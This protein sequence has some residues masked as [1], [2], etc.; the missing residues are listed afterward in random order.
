MRKRKFLGGIRE[1][2]IL[3]GRAEGQHDGPSSGS[4]N[5]WKSEERILFFLFGK[6]NS[7]C[8]RRLFCGKKRV[9]IRT[10]QTGKTPTAGKRFSRN[11]RTST[12]GDISTSTT[13]SV[14]RIRTEWKSRFRLSQL[15]S[16]AGLCGIGVYGTARRLKKRQPDLVLPC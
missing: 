4:L 16:S 1:F 7:C 11:D 10:Y 3:Y 13:Y 15:I 2:E 12:V 8:G 6:E 9:Q 5:G 14:F